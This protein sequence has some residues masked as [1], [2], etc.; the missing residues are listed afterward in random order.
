MHSPAEMLD[1]IEGIEKKSCTAA[2]ARIVA[3]R[4]KLAK[5]L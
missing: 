5:G 4:M 3:L 2:V 1:E